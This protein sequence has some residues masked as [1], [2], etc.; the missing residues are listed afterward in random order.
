MKRGG[1]SQFSE[2]SGFFSG[3]TMTSDSMPSGWLMPKWYDGR[4]RNGYPQGELNILV[5][6]L[7]GQAGN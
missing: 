1:F 6:T 3:L 5:T 2:N 4:L 7:L